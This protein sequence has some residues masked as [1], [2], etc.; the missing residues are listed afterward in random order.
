MLRNLPHL[1][2]ACATLAFTSGI[3]SA[4]V[5]KRVPR[6]LKMSTLS[7]GVPSRNNKDSERRKQY[8][9]RQIYRTHNPTGSEI[10]LDELQPNSQ[11]PTTTIKV[12]W[13][14]STC[15]ARQTNIPLTQSTIEDES[16]RTLID[17]HPPFHNPG[18]LGRK[19]NGQGRMVR[20][21]KLNPTF[22]LI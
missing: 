5:V 15:R 6:Y 12:G 21:Y 10:F 7:S 17:G 13:S 18:R 20:T 1:V 8:D 22:L 11:N 19:G 14:H 2:I 3:W 9:A 4:S 16:R